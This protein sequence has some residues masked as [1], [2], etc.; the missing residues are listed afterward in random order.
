MRYYGRLADTGSKFAGVDNEQISLPPVK[1]KVVFQDVKYQF[2]NSKV[3]QVDGINLEIPAG[4]F[5][6]IVGQVEAGKVL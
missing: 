2:S 4:S 1:G 6:G 3:F 5:V